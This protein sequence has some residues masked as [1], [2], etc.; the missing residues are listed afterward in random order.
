[1]A[2]RNYYEVLGVSRGASAEEIKKAYRQLALKYHPDRNP[3]DKS[4]EE[5]FK[6]LG[7][8]YEVLSDP[9]RRPQYDQVG[10]EAFTGAWG[11]GRSRAGSTPPGGFHDPFEIFRDVFGGGGDVFEQFFGETGRRRKRSG[12]ERGSDLRHDMEISFEEA[13]FGVEKEISVHKLDVCSDCHGSGAQAGSRKTT[14]ITCH[15]RGQVTMS[16]GFFT[17]SQTCPHCHGEGE[18]AEKP[19]S[20][21]RGEG[22]ME[23]SSKIKVNI[24]AGIEEGAR[25]RSQGHGEAGVR[26]GPQGDLYIVVHVRSNKIFQRHGQDIVCEIPIHFSTA[27]LGGEIEAPTLNG[28]AKIKIPAGTQ[29][30]TVFRLAGKGLPN[31]RGYGRGDQHVRIIVEVPRNL[32]A[33]QRKKLEEFADLCGDD[34]NPMS[35]GFFDKAKDWFAK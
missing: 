28:K 25:L 5:K 26:G 27:A 17:L 24:P 16:R 18:V 2:K 23:H 35:K 9:E 21:C 3:G 20:H 13:A 6:E 4:A 19:C 11:S 8:A 7:E 34:V 15:G 1:M 14:C 29:S 33:A 32:N 31:V 10:H 22:R 12:G 30:G